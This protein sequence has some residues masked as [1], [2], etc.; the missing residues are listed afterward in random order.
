MRISLLIITIVV[1]FSCN[2]TENKQNVTKNDSIATI[3]S[4]TEK[5]RTDPRNVSLLIQRAKL[6]SQRNQPQDAINDLEVAVSIDSLQPQTYFDLS[7][8]Y[9]KAAKSSKSKEWLEKAL[10]LF[11]DSADVHIKLAQLHLFVKEYVKSM[12]YLAK[13]EELNNNKADIYFL[14]GIIYKEMAD[15]N[16]A[17]ENFQIAKTINPDYYD[18]YIMLG[19]LLSNRKD[20]NAVY[21]YKNAINLIPMST[22]AH[23]NLGY[24]YQNIYNTEKAINEYNTIINDIDSSYFPAYYNIGFIKM[25]FSKDYKEA[26]NYF[27]K[28]INHRSNYYEAFHNRGFCHEQLKQYDEAKSDYE[29]ALA[30][31]PNYELSLLGLNRIDKIK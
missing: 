26:I 20:S 7:E 22:E 2:T 6:F 13:A 9:I 29:S 25:N 15:T 1:L 23:Y 8:A 19:N 12:Q 14:K 18:A 17:L 27:T 4:V 31:F 3:E 24:Y 11:P 28:A 16:K 5:I 21:F 30:I 10:K